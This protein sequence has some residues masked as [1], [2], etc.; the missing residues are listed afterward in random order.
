ME[1]RRRHQRRQNCR[2]R[3]LALKTD[4]AYEGYDDDWEPQKSLALKADGGRYKDESQSDYDAECA[5]ACYENAHDLLDWRLE[6]L[7]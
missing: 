5:N 6:D 3:P 4:E 7:K 2:I 1:R